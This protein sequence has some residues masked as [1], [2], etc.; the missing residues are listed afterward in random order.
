MDY[1]DEITAYVMENAKPTSDKIKAII[2]EFDH[3]VEKYGR[4]T[5]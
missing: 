3:W 2:D 5:Y 4:E 1:L